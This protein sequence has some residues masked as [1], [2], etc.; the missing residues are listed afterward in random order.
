M[1]KE[2]NGGVLRRTQQLDYC[3]Q[4]GYCMQRKDHRIF[5]ETTTKAE[6]TSRKKLFTLKRRARKHLLTIH[7][8]RFFDNSES[9]QSIPFKFTK[10]DYD[11]LKRQMKQLPCWQ[12]TY[13]RRTFLAINSKSYKL[14]LFPTHTLEKKT[15][16]LSSFKQRRMTCKKKRTTV[17]R[18]NILNIGKLSQTKTNYCSKL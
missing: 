12:N 2:Y 8:H 13:L 16:E 1:R 17:F 3:T 11:K 7:K 5:F 4:P 14:N 15:K 10:K 18:L 6:L 9:Q